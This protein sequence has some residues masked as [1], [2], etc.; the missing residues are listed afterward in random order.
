MPAIT[1]DISKGSI[2]KYVFGR[3]DVAASLTDSA[4]L[5]ADASTNVDYP[6]LWAADV[7]GLAYT[8]SAAPTAG[9]ASMT[10]TVNGTKNA[11]TTKSFVVDSS[12]RTGVFLI[13][14]GAVTVKAGDRLGL[15]ITTNAG[16]LPIT[17]DLTVAVAVVH[18]VEGI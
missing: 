13:P 8:F 6:M 11:T 3:A 1:R 9:T 15:V 12:T 7:V 18:Y 5:N 14:R 17:T 10:V 16:W 2:L 4:V